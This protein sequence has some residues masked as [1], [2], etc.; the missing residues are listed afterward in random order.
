MATGINLSLV[1]NTRDAIREFQRTG[2]SLEDVASSLEDVAREGKTTGSKI[3]S[4]MRNVSRTS[5]DTADDL[6]KDFRKAFDSVKKESKDAGRKI[7]RDMDDA[8]RSAGA[9]TGEFKD[10][11]RQNFSEVTSSFDGSMDSIADLAQGTLGGLAGSL[12]GPIGLV[13]GAAA[14]AGGLF[15]AHW[16]ENAEKVE[17]R[18]SDMYDDMI[19]SGVDF[20][21]RQFIT[22]Q[23]QEIYNKTEDAAIGWEHMQRI[24]K[25][26]GAEE[27]TVARAFAGDAD[28]RKQLLDDIAKKYGELSDEQDAAYGDEKIAI[29]DAMSLLGQYG[30][31][32][33]A[34]GDTQDEAASRVRGFRDAVKEMNTELLNV[35]YK[36]DANV[37]LYFDKQNAQRE[38]DTFVSDI[39]RRRITLSIDPRLTS[40]GRSTA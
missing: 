12:A 18:I 37:S 32:V 25:A 33:R 34:L 3:E 16:K 20:V 17:E 31:E 15:Y 36:T 40:N 14:A 10:E 7:E 39:E 28:A 19:E 11:A 22:D 9:V 24:V 4:E 26:S 8:G 13:A 2:E 29:G 6:E 38:I 35:P 30:D 23:L 1:A 21:S 5:D 27:A